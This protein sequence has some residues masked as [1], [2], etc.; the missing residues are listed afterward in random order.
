MHALPLAVAS[1]HLLCW[2]AVNSGGSHAGP[3]SADPAGATVLHKLVA[4]GLRDAAAAYVREAQAA[5]LGAC[6]VDLT[7]RDAAGVTALQIAE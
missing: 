5:P 7:A 3:N 1:A 4:A 6:P 2:C